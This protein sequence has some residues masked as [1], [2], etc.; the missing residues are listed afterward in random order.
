MAIYVQLIS[1]RIW[2]PVLI[3]DVDCSRWEFF[4]A[5]HGI[6]LLCY[7]SLAGGFLTDRWLGQADPGFEGLENRSLTKYRLIIDEYSTQWEDFQA[8]LR[9]MRKIADRRGTDIAGVAIQWVLRQSISA[10][11]AAV[12]G[13]VTTYFEMPNPI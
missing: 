4:C 1:R 8:L 7:G 9:L 6:E 13:G 10:K 12:A 11:E 5:Q 3:A 2:N